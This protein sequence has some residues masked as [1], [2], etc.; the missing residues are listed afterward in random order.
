MDKAQVRAW[1]RDAKQRDALGA[2]DTVLP[3]QRL[4]DS[5]LRELD[6]IMS[7]VPPQPGTK[8]LSIFR[9]AEGLPESYCATPVVAWAVG[10]IACYPIGDNSGLGN[11][12]DEIDAAVQWPD[13]QVGHLSTLYVDA[14]TWWREWATWCRSKGEAA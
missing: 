11:L 4:V 6:V 12:L 14:E 9:D 13:G 7:I 8:L 2:R 1:Q 3:L 5:D 10:R